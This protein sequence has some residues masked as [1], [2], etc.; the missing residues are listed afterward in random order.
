MAAHKAYLDPNDGQLMAQ[1]C[2]D[3]DGDVL[4]KDV[5]LA[6]L[7]SVHSAITQNYET[8]MRLRY[9]G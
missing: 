4:N 3:A 1:K 5:L 2:P 7:G 8:L 9:G 6:A